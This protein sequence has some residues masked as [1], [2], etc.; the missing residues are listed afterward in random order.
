MRI[1]VY[2]G[3]FDPVTLAHL[4]IARRAT[5]IFDRVI[6]AVF[7][8]PQKNLLFTTEERL[9]LL[10]EATVS[11]TGVE[12]MAYQILT[13]DFARSVGACALVRGLRTVSDFEAEY[14][15]AQINQALDDSIEVVLL[16]AGRHYGHV[17]SS[18]V[19]EMA[20]L[21]REPVNFAPPHVLA[22]LREKFT[23]GG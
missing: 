21:G 4:D 13:V 10:R 5:R 16:A 22:A 20:A 9:D 3:S 2:P 18:A 15:M 14:Q 7:D 23:R 12:V 8:R 17:S 19:R 11:M 1:A 6:M